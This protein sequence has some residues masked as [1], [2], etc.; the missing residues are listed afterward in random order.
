MAHEKRS[1]GR[2]RLRDLIL[3][4][5]NSLLLVITFAFLLP[6]TTHATLIGNLSGTV[7]VHE[8]NGTLHSGILDE[9]RIRYTQDV[10]TTPYAIHATINS[11][12]S[13][14]GT[15][16]KIDELDFG[17][18]GKYVILNFRSGGLFGNLGAIYDELIIINRTSEPGRLSFV[19][20]DLSE[21]GHIE[22]NFS[23]A[24]FYFDAPTRFDGNINTTDNITLEKNR[25]AIFMGERYE[26][27]PTAVK[28]H[29]NI[30]AG[31]S[32]YPN[33]TIIQKGSPSNFLG[34]HNPQVRIG[35]NPILGSGNY[36]PYITGDGGAILAETFTVKSGLYVVGR[37]EKGPFPQLDASIK[38]YDANATELGAAFEPGNGGFGYD[39]NNDKLLL[40][41]ASAESDVPVEVSIDGQVWNWTDTATW[42][43]E[44]YITNDGTDMI[45]NMTDDGSLLI[46]N[47]TGYGQI[48]YGEA[49]EHTH[50]ETT[51]NPLETFVN[52]DDYEE[53]EVTVYRTNT[54]DC[55]SIVIDTQYCP[56]G[57]NMACVESLDKISQEL[58]GAYEQI[59]KTKTVCTKYPVQAHSVSCTLANI[60]GSLADLNNNVDLSE[61][62][63][64][65]D[66]G[67][68]AEEIYTQ[69]RTISPNEDYLEKFTRENLEDKETHKNYVSNIKGTGK[70]GL[71][72]EARIVELE[73]AILELKAEIEKLKKR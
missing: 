12:F 25:S 11:T 68:M 46:M 33:D 64:D 73:G 20:D 36:I 35:H 72:M 55:E 71:D 15:S 32:T 65:F 22:F 58:W 57:G 28:A 53:C 49:V 13:S 26:S 21:L 70:D 9:A 40:E 50:N 23:T 14:D 19:A 45:V 39:S 38:V 51:D 31:S 47:S 44:A 41:T 24:E 69:S 48:E 16:L 63:T 60:R 42:Y 3:T 17:A 30:Y 37:P 52:P 67:I 6:T 54:S 56:F 10:N 18:F 8:L 2:F 34:I 43:E 62:L 1:K 66:T 5:T 4:N 7:P 27:N 29:T 61:N 59:N